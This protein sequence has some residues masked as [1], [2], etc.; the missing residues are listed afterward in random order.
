MEMSPAVILM[1][2]ACAY[3]IFDAV[4]LAWKT[5]E[6]AP[7]NIPA[8]LQR[9]DDGASELLNVAAEGT[10]AAIEHGVTATH[11][12]VAEAAACEAGPNLASHAVHAI[13]HLFHH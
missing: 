12:C 7:A 4:R 2:L 5:R 13:A 10:S 9:Q 3:G 6:A 1:L 11:H 8:S